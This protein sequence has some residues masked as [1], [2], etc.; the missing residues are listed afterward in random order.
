MIDKLTWRE[1]E[2]LDL[3]VKGH[4]NQEIADALYLSINS[5]KTYIS[6]AYRKMGVTRRTQAVIWGLKHSSPVTSEPHSL[7]LTGSR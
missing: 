6:S 3:I 1:V 7:E 4:T 2:V 5:I